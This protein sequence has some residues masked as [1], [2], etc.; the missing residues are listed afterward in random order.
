MICKTDVNMH[1]WVLSMTGSYNQIIWWKLLFLNK[2]SKKIINL[3]LIYSISMHAKMA[4]NKH[5]LIFF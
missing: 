1:I 5:K 4:A 2:K 3:A